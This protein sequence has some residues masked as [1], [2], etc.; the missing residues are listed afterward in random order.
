MENSQLLPGTIKYYLQRKKLTPKEVREDANNIFQNYMSYKSKNVGN[1][2]IMI[3][4]IQ[5]WLAF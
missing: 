3:S 4:S 1:K 5:V 2:N